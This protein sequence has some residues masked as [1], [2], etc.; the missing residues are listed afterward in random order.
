MGRF[1]IPAPPLF[2]AAA[3]LTLV[4]AACSGPASPGQT[5]T[6]SGSGGVGS[7]TLKIGTVLPLSGP[8][9]TIGKYAQQ[10][11]DL[12][13]EEINAK[14]GIDGVMLQAIHTDGKAA[15]KDSVDAFN[16]LSSVDQVPVVITLATAPLLAI[17]PIS[18]AAGVL[19]MCGGCNSPV[20][21]DAGHLYLNNTSL[22][23]NEGKV[24]LEYVI[25]KLGVKTLAVLGTTDEAGKSH[26]QWAK[27]NASALGL[28]YLGTEFADI[29][30]SDIS[31]Q[32][33]KIK[34]LDPDVVYMTAFGQDLS[35]ALKQAREGGLDVPI[36]TQAAVQTPD[37]IE[38][39]GTNAENVY[40][41]YAVP[42]PD[43]TIPA[44]QSFGERYNAKYGEMP[45]QFA[46][47]AYDLVQFL[48]QGVAKLQDGGQALNG[49][50]LWKAITDIHTFEGVGG[51]TT[52]QA[53]GTATKPVY[54]KMIKD[55]E[56]VYAPE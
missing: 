1:R 12:A 28:T 7:T 2:S 14:G 23:E 55:G 47:N 19:L 36:V 16:K 5:T 18:D 8:A 25:D 9:A 49:E 11:I 52:F 24:A 33:A 56:F 21:H 3:C 43:K 32:I 31:T 54:A 17:A 41:G 39:A 46:G 35:L 13:V 29:G 34:A 27:D 20:T 42:P 10:G 53:D 30:S 6:P 15:A 38:A 48:A 45:E 51:E 37:T 4:L 22:G 26:A 50:N 40:Y 44:F